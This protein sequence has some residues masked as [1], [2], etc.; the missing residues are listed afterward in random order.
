MTIV[1]AKR[2]G[3]RVAICSDTKISAPRLTRNLSV[4][5]HLKVVVLRENLT[6]CIAGSYASGLH[7]IYKL[8]GLRSDVC[9]SDVVEHFC[10]LT[11]DG[12]TDY[13]VVSHEDPHNPSIHKISSGRVA[14]DIDEG[15]IGCDYEVIED[16]EIRILRM[17]SIESIPHVS[18]D[19]IKFTDA[20]SAF[21][22]DDRSSRFVEIG[23]VPIRTLCSPFGHCYCDT[24]Y[25]SAW[26]RICLSTD[27]TDE[28]V[29]DQITGKTMFSVNL[30][31]P[32]IRGVPVLGLYLPQVSMG[33][34][35][36]P[37]YSQNPHRTNSMQIGAFSRA[38]EHWALLRSKE[39]FPVR[40]LQLYG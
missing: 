21:M 36:D 27:I 38:V 1:Y 40:P 10:R 6:I 31:T 7:E 23:G 34:I 16:I 15:Y 5:G 33:W 25:F 37:M 2:F 29:Y 20:F 11:V 30:I 4:P 18:D 14:S 28:Q 39:R 22:R 8:F 32:P 24:A 3:S 13:L 35:Y 9:L 19:E 17:G 26:D 12:A